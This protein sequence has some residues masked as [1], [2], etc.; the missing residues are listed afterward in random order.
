MDMDMDMDLDKDKDKNM[1]MDMDII[2]HAE[3]KALPISRCNTNTSKLKHAE[4]HLQTTF[5]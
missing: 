2:N 5:K 4:K 3:K 1:S